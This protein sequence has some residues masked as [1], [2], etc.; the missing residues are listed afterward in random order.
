MAD[1][2][3]HSPDKSRSRSI[4]LRLSQGEYGQLVNLARDTHQSV[5]SLVRHL[6]FDSIAALKK[7]R[8]FQ[9]IKSSR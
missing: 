2:K 4:T 3:K 7:L 1:T 8:G 5:S 9:K 6:C